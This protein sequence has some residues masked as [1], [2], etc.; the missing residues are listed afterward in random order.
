M[1][2][3]PDIAAVLLDVIMETDAAGLAAGRIHPQRTEERDRPHH[4]AHRPAR[5]GAGAAGDRRL[6]HQRLQGQDRAHRRQAVHLAD[7]GAAQLPAARAHGADPARAGDHH[8]CGV[9]ALRLQ[10]D[11]AAGRGRADADRIAAQCR[12]RRHPGAARRQGQSTTSS[13]CWPAPAAIAATSPP[14]PN[15]SRSIRR[16]RRWSSRHSRSASTNFSK[17]ARCSTCAPAA[18]AK[19]SCCWRPPRTFPTPTGRWWRFS[20]AACRSPST[21][22][23][24]TSSCRSAN[25]QLEDRVAQRTRALMSANRRLSAQWLRLQRANAFKNE[26]LG[27]VAHDLKNPLGVILGRTEMLKELISGAMASK[28]GSV[29]AGGPHPRRHQAADADGRSPDL[30]CD[31][32]RLRHHDPARAGRYRRPGDGDRRDE[33]AIRL[34]Q[35]AD[36]QRCRRR[37]SA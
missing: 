3:N 5:P 32:R 19:S 11:A 18:A 12:L 28:E 21:T 10:V 22:S 25:T 15:P 7:R 4:P 37:P 30:G 17:T 29:V 26:V 9:D 20:P 34:Q 27:T 8:R 36:D 2:D 33:P 31:G 23:S 6:R 13:R 24:S 1:R 35:A 16:S 14:T